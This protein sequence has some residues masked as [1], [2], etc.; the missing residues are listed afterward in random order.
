MD[1]ERL[2]VDTNVLVYANAAE[3]P[4]HQRALTALKLWGENETELWIS[5]QVIREY[6]ALRT[7]PQAFAAP[8]DRELLIKRVR[9][10]QERFRV[11]YETPR[12]AEKLLMLIQQVDVGGKQIHDA[13][14]V[15]TMLAQ[16][17][18][19]LLSHNVSDFRRFD[20]FITVVPL[21]D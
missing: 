16:G 6:A 19:H 18:T 17:I 1:A 14:I 9:Y 7:R 11:A 4:L 12:V 15:A 20:A 5:T 8:V 10:F 2:F 21:D 3:A 13:N